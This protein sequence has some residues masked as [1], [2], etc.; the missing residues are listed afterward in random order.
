MTQWYLNFFG[1]VQFWFSAIASQFF[2]FALSSIILLLWGQ[3]LTTS[4]VCFDHW[5]NLLPSTWMVWNFL[6][7]IQKVVHICLNVHIFF[8]PTFTTNRRTY[9]YFFSTCATK[10]RKYTFV[11]TKQRTYM[12]ICACSYPFFNQLKNWW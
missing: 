11:W 4:A 2:I 3:E 9:M 5:Q 6:Q 10:W 1:S 8:Y 7:R 12:S